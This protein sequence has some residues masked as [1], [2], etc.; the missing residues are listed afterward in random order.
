[1]EAGRAFGPP[2]IRVDLGKDAIMRD[3]PSAE[4]TQMQRQHVMVINGAP[5]FLNLMRELLQDERYNVTTSN[6][7]PTSFDQIAGMRPSLLIIDLAV[8]QLAGWDLLERLALEAMTRDLP[9]IV[10]STDPR[11]LERAEADRV[12]YGGRAWI[13]KPFDIDDLLRE[14]DRLIGPA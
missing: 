7:V 3:A 8:H 1:V 6:F 10:V 14:I 9:V 13:A 11:L 5:V 4:S 2:S 12:R